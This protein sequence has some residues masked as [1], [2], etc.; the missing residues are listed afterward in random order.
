MKFLFSFRFTVEKSTSSPLYNVL[1][2]RDFWLI[3]QWIL[4]SPHFSQFN[5]QNKPY[6]WTLPPIA[7]DTVTSC[8]GYSRFFKWSFNHE[9][10]FIRKKESVPS[11]NTNSRTREKKYVF[12]S[13]FTLLFFFFFLSQY[14]SFPNFDP[15]QSYWERASGKGLLWWLPSSLSHLLASYSAAFHIVFLSHGDIFEIWKIWEIIHF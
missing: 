13:L 15:S 11:S 9:G 3:L 10:V 5:P 7:I 12:H 1:K 6:A 14:K 2:E 8:L 4:F